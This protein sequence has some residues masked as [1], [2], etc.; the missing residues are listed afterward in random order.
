MH[1]PDHPAAQSN[2]YVSEHR[3]VLERLL[4]RY[5]I[6]GEKVRHRNQDRADNRPENLELMPV[7]ATSDRFWDKVHKSDGCWTWEGRHQRIGYGIFWIDSNPYLAHRVSYTMAFG[8][9]PEGLCVCHRCD[10]RACVRPSHLFLG[11]QRDNMLDM[12]RKRRRHCLSQTQVDAARAL[13]QCGKTAK[14]IAH[15]FGVSPTTIGRDIRPGPACGE[16]NCKSKLTSQTV[17]QI[18]LRRAHG[19]GIRSLASAF[20]VGK[21][22]IRRVVAFQTWKNVAP[23]PVATTHMIAEDAH[24]KSLFENL[25]TSFPEAS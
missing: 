9:I 17:R 15:Q 16:R 20:G 25:G 12:S 22:A 21:V 11:T 6:P 24:H 4:G 19:E 14:T 10:N 2:G 8:P 3:L 5:L 23:F 13:I 1:C 7:R 18:R